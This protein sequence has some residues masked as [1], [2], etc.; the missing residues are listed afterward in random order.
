MFVDV[1]FQKAKP[2]GKN[3]VL[4]IEKNISDFNNK[5]TF[6]YYVMLKDSYF[7]HW[8]FNKPNKFYYFPPIPLLLYFLF[9][10]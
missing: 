5:N 9:C 6:K 1:L 3:H 10:F 2:M 4:L 8:Y 7:V